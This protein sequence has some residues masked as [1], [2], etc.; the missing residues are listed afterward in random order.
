MSVYENTELWSVLL[1]HSLTYPSAEPQDMVK[2]VYQK[3]FLR[4]KDLFLMTNGRL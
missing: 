2:L 4:K 1:E 3:L